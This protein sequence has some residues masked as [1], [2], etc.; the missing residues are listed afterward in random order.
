MHILS[1]CVIIKLYGKLICTVT[2]L[3]YHAPNQTHHVTKIIM[4]HRNTGQAKETYIINCITF[5][6]SNCNYP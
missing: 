4:Y 6:A 1:M 3:G 5:I 2:I